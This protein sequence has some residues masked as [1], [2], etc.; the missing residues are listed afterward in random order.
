MLDTAMHEK[1][2]GKMEERSIGNPDAEPSVD[3]FFRA[4]SGQL[5]TAAGRYTWLTPRGL[6]V[7]RDITP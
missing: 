6:L 3:R 4:F 1:G 7:F 2:E 5:R